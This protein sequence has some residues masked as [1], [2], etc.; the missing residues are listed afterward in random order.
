MFFSSSLLSTALS[1]VVNQSFRIALRLHDQ[2][3]IFDFF[4]ISET[5]DM[6]LHGPKFVSSSYTYIYLS[7]DRIVYSSVNYTII[8][9]D[10]CIFVSDPLLSAARGQRVTHAESSSSIFHFLPRTVEGVSRPSYCFG[11]VPSCLNIIADMVQSSLE[12]IRGIIL[13]SRLHVGSTSSVCS[14]FRVRI[15]FHSPWMSEIYV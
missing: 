2:E 13:C 9:V 12:R 7:S 3:S 14:N 8:V 4:N 10:M 15:E 6:S 5:S 11:S 1:S